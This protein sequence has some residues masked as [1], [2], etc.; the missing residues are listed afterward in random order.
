MEAMVNLEIDGKQ[1]KARQG[2][3]VLEAAKESGVQIPTLCFH[4]KIMP[5]GACRVCSV[6]VGKKGGR[7][8]VVAACGYPAEDGLVVKTRSP[9]IDKIRKTIVELVAPQAMF[10]GEVSGELKEIADEYGADI[11]RFESRLN[12]KPVRCIL[13][14]ECVRYCAEV[15]GANAIGF[16]GRGIERRVVFFPE[17]ASKV[18]PG[19]MGCF[20]ICPT[21]KIAAEAD[22]TY[23]GFTVDRFLA[24]TL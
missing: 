19:C 16:V 21:G 18:C 7:V 3:T 10:E 13:C 17:K 1:V 12:V 6:E 2:M 15:V 20:E 24:G 8:R 9:R 22:G 4:D 5:Y 11:H 14:G 23:F